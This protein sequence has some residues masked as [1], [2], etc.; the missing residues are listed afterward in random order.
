MNIDGSTSCGNCP[1]HM[2]STD[3]T[4]GTIRALEA[5]QDKLRSDL[6]SVAATAT[7]ADAKAASLA[8]EVARL[9]RRMHSPAP[10]SPARPAFRVY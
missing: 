2:Q 1:L 10:G 4:V 8:A 6:H 9:Q 3:A 5:R 7:L